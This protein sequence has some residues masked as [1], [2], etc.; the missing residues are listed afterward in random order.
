[1]TRPPADAEACSA[2]AC[3]RPVSARGLCQTHYVAGWR[4]GQLPP[5]IDRTWSE[6]PLNKPKRHG[7]KRTP[8]DIKFSK[9]VRERDGWTCQRCG[10]GYAPNS[11]GLHC[12]HMFSRG[13]LATRYDLSNARA[14]CYGCHRWLDTHPDLKREFFRE[15]LG[16]EA[17]AA[18]ELRSNTPYKGIAPKPKPVEKT[19]TKC[20]E[21]KPIA[22][23]YF[24]NRSSGRPHYTSRCKSCVLAGQHNPERRRRVDHARRLRRYGLT[25][26]E[27]DLLVAVQKNRCA[28]CGD[29]PDAQGRN[30]E[31]LHIDHDAVTGRVRGLLCSRCNTGIGLLREDERILTA[32]L[33]Y[34]AGA[35]EAIA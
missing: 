11:K 4:Q 7:I 6:L 26:S 23:F 28:I 27:Y 9:R 5:K 21:T 13:K 33:A 24:V 12:A 15:W 1:M 8:E 35:Q 30:R 2:A 10:K 17:F 19:C 34:L 18:L 25:E 3:D 20:G 16:D 31:T 22:E 29:P 14:L 32:A